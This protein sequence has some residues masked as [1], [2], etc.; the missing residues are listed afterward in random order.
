[1]NMKFYPFILIFLVI[2]FL[3]VSYIDARGGGGGHGG[4]GRGGSFGGF[5][6]RGG[7]GSLGGRGGGY[8]GI[9]GGGFARPVGRPVVNNY[10]GGGGIRRG[11]YGGIG[12]APILIGGYGG[13]GSYGSYGSYGRYRVVECENP[14]SSF[15]YGTYVYPPFGF[16]YG[17]C[18]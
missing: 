16:G 9:S 11:Y 17:R 12:I 4:G 6:G 10:Y 2:L 3:N 5:G 8:H 15:G 1:M 7:Y 13:Y 18:Y 14:F